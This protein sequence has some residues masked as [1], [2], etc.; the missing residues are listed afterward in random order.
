MF[1]ESGL[2]S[3]IFSESNKPIGLYRC[4]QADSFRVT[5]L[6]RLRNFLISVTRSVQSSSLER[7]D[8]HSP[9]E[10]FTVLPC[11][12]SFYSDG[13]RPSSDGLQP[14]SVSFYFS[15]LELS[16]VNVPRFLF[17]L[18][19]ALAIRLDGYTLSQTWAR[20]GSF[21]FVNLQ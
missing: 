13:L 12:I 18:P 16:N 3:K 5:L 14:T 6:P 15:I 4:G 19:P 1:D 11:G 7:V 21:W 20:K 8:G 9:N 2:L 10:R 17:A